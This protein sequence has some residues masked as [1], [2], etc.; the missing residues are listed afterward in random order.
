MGAPVWNRKGVEEH[1]V[2]TLEGTAPVPAWHRY[3]CERRCGKQWPRS[4]TQVEQAVLK[5]IEDHRGRVVAGVD[6]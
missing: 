1:P 5:A 4:R 3:P 2:W 6:L